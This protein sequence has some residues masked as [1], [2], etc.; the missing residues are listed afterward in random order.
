MT[1]ENE[2]PPGC[3]GGLELDDWTTVKTSRND[4]H[5][6]PLLQAPRC[7]L[8]RDA[9][10]RLRRL[11]SALHALGE[12]PLYEFLREVEAGADMRARLEVYAQ[13]P[14]AFVRVNGGDRFP[15]E[16]FAVSGGRGQ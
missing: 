14:G 3:A 12:R 2:N 7:A 10:L 6:S 1:A 5:S 8:A 15:P 16:A 4:S 13:L 11:A 9:E